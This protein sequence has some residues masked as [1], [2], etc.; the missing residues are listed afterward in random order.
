M[1]VPATSEARSSSI[2][3]PEAFRDLLVCGLTLH[4]GGELVVGAGHLPDLIP[5][6]H[7]HPYGATLVGHCTLHRLPNPPGGV[8]GEPPSTAG[9]ELLDGL[10]ETYVALLD[11]VLE[12][13]P[14]PAVLLGY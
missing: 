9:I 11:E 12:G 8:R 5:H 2:S 6:V 1:T 13:Q 3:S 14:H 7:R 4:L 10:H